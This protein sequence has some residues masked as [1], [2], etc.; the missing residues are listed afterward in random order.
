MSVKRYL[1]RS[2]NDD[3]DEVDR[4]APGEC[5][6]ETG[7]LQTIV[8]LVF[9]SEVLLQTGPVGV[10]AWTNGSLLAFDCL[11]GVECIS[12]TAAGGLFLSAYVLFLLRSIT[13]IHLA[14]S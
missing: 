12:S 13:D 9:A 3:D 6:P 5:T 8:E 1:P 2:D 14:L 11:E 7:V 10:M 4:N